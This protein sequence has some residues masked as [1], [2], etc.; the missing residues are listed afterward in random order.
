MPGRH[1]AVMRACLLTLEE[2][3]LQLS[4]GDLDLDG[5]V[6]LLLVS[7]LVVGV[8]LDGRREQRVDE[9]GLAQARLSSDLQVSHI[10][11]PRISASRKRVATYHD[12]ESGTALSNN[13]VSLVGQIGNAN[14]RRTLGSG[15]RHCVYRLWTMLY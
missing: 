12:C 5:L 15:R 4:L 13:L 6:N 9:G 7:A 3:L 14:R 11:A 10:S 8:V 2:L 1:H